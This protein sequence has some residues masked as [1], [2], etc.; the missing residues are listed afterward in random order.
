MSNACQLLHGGSAPATPG[1]NAVAPEWLYGAA[2]AAPAVPAAE[3]TLGSHP[4]VA[5]S[6][7]QVLPEWINRNLAGKVL[8]A[9]GDNPLNFVSHSRGS[10]HFRPPAPRRP[11]A[12]P[13]P[14]HALSVGANAGRLRRRRSRLCYSLTWSAEWQNCTRSSWYRWF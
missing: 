9:N 6:S 13:S 5:L 12:S 8:A 11:P 3:S 1:F 2:E 10:L 4:C 14:R 7:A